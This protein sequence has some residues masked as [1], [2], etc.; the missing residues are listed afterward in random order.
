[1]TRYTPAVALTKNELQSY[2]DLVGKQLAWLIKA[3]KR[4][5]QRGEGGAV[6]Q[7]TMRAIDT[8]MELRMKAHYESCDGAGKVNER[9]V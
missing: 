6:Y 2:S 8:M 3:R 5:E 7:A 9:E 4:L 1:M